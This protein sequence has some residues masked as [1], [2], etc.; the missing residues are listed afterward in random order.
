MLF[1]CHG[2]APPPSRIDPWRG[3]RPEFARQ[4]AEFADRLL[5]E[6]SGVAASRQHPGVLWTHNDSGNDPWLFATD[7]AGRAIGRWPVG[8]IRNRDWED[9]A[10]G[11]CPAGTCLY[12]GDVGDNGERR[13]QVTLHRIPEPDPRLPGDTIHQVE[14]LV[15]TYP[16]RPRDV[17]AIYVD[18]S[19]DSWLISKGRSEGV[20]RYRVSASAWDAGATTAEL[21][22][23][24]PI[25]W[26]IG[27]AHRVTGASLSA[28]GQV[29]VVRTYRELYRFDRL[30]GG[31]LA[32]GAGSNRCRIAGLEPQGEAVDWL[33]D[34][35][36]VLTSERAG[37]K[38]GGVYLVA[39]P[40]GTGR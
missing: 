13:R 32:P 40:W 35:I 11:P 37:S 7:T 30:P 12:I 26:G 1:A 5:G 36:L 31:G 4:T 23:T 16:D 10:L 33:D 38:R 15:V 14:S 9:I 19:G 8:Q 25:P 2:G 22:D 17:E 20:L 18:D 3:A 39:C 34:R 6:S 28:D 27:S 21:V 29:L 24:L